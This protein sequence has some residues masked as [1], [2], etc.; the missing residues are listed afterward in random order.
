V[1]TGVKRIFNFQFAICDLKKANGRRRAV[2]CA[3]ATALCLSLAMSAQGGEAAI[4]PIKAE[5]GETHTEHLGPVTSICL[6]AGLNMVSASEDGAIIGW[7]VSFG[8]L[9]FKAYIT[10]GKSKPLPVS[11]AMSCDLIAFARKDGTVDIV[12]NR[13]G[14]EL[15][16]KGNRAIAFTSG[17]TILATGSDGE[18]GVVRLWDASTG[19]ET[20]A[21]NGHK[22]AIT[23]LAFSPDGSMVAS[24]GSDREIRLWEVSGGKLQRT[25]A[26]DETGAISSLAFSADGTLL[27]S[28][29]ADNAV[30]VWEV[31]SG[32]KNISLEGHNGPVNVVRFAHKD[33]LT[34]AMLGTVLIS[35]GA[36]G[37]VRFW[38]ISDGKELLKIDA[39]AAPV[40]SL[41]CSTKG[42]D[43]ITGSDD[44]SI[45][46]WKISVDIPLPASSERLHPK[47]APVTVKL[48]LL[49]TY[50]G[51]NNSPNNVAVSRDG[52]RVASSTSEISE[53]K[54]VGKI[55]S[56]K[57]KGEI[58][59]WSS[60]EGPKEQVFNFP[61]YGTG[62]VSLSPDGN[63]LSATF[64]DDVRYLVFKIMDV[65]TGKWTMER[66]GF[67]STAMFSPDGSRIAVEGLTESGVVTPI[68]ILDLKKGE[69]VKTYPGYPQ[70]VKALAFSRNGE[71]L[72][73]GG[74][75]NVVQL[76]GAASKRLVSHRESLVNYE[77]IEGLAISP[78]GRHMAAARGNGEGTISVWDCAT[79]REMRCINVSKGGL[80]DIAFLGDD[81]TVVISKNTDVEFWDIETGKQTSS[82]KAHDESINTLALSADG[83]KLVVGS[84]VKT[85]KLWEIEG[86]VEI[87]KQPK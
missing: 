58:R 75:G 27:A 4:P 54:K 23:A 2:S 60:R 52:S 79:G 31:K 65:N 21:L 44:K 59:T 46:I 22:G 64:G 3:A 29:G 69:T 76:W 51:L 20:Q 12:D 28:A 9:D 72:A 82:F 15:N 73:S 78:D 56:C 35:G 66:K 84:Y 1:E 87:L 5:P 71:I 45:K 16:V 41:G 74:A 57:F 81:R 38:R 37:T 7:S 39:H 14:K 70:S 43:L 18:G 8:R 11:I 53:M 62:R 34:Q 61:D 77:A 83:K 36:D 42:R 49:E 86:A 19:K 25:I 26:G 47:N 30:K 13:T 17:G 68:H 80:K 67:G 85:I 24:G 32:K 33:S 50:K 63:Y 48:R 55:F 6:D 10:Y 40:R